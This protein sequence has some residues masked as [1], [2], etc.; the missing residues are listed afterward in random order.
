MFKGQSLEE[1]SSVMGSSTK[2]ALLKILRVERVLIYLALHNDP[3]HFI[4][5]Y[6]NYLIVTASMLL[7]LNIS[8]IFFVLEC[9]SVLFNNSYFC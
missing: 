5:H 6:L 2:I 7:F 1:S 8:R 3:E 9:N 4:V